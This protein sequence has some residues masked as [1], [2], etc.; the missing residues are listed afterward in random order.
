M[1][2]LDKVIRKHE[3]VFQEGLETLEGYQATLHVDLNASPKFC[4]AR[5]VPY[6]M[7]EL[8]EKELDL[9]VE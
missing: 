8:V 7:Q 5:T 2:A 9:L 4:K 6:A 3:K 1:K